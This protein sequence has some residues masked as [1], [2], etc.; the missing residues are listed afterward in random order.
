[1]T[2]ED[3]IAALKEAAEERILMLDGAM[4]T[5]IQ[6]YKLDE[7]GYRGDALPR[8]SQRDL[9]GNNDLLMLTQPEIIREI[10]DAYL[11][12]G[13]DILETNTFNAQLDL[14]RPTTA[15]RTIAHEMNVAAAQARARGG[16]RLDAEDA[17]QAALRRRRAR[18]DQP[19]RLD[20]ARCQ[21]SG[22]PRCQLRCAG[23]GLRD[24]GARADRGR[25]RPDP[26]RD[27]LRHAERQGR[28]LRRRAGFR[29][30][31]RRACRSWSPAPSPISPAARS[32]ARRR[33]PS[34][35]RCEHLRPFAVGLNCA[36][37]AE[38]MRP[39]VDEICSCRRY[40]DLRLSQCRPPERIRRL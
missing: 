2:R 35:T 17:G 32:P 34:G 21:R 38:E 9:K 25:R 30:D 11:E 23:R 26:D 39:S 1:M 8:S 6:R 24:A 7:A 36:F 37:G 33:R 19:H 13:A 4:G 5:M 22:L 12:A 28:D 27:H 14:R 40:A 18:P 15:S 16:R 29:R 10:H 20:L 3:R 31:G